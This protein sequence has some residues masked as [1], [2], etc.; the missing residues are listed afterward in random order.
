MTQIRHERIITGIIGSLSIDGQPIIDSAQIGK[1]DLP[2]DGPSLRDNSFGIVADLGIGNFTKHNTC[3]VHE[4]MR[5]QHGDRTGKVFTGLVV[6]LVLGQGSYSQESPDLTVIRS[7]DHSFVFEFRPR[8]LAAKTVGSPGPQYAMHDFVGSVSDHSREGIGHPDVRFRAIPIGFPSASGHTVQVVQADYEEVMNIVPA[9]VPT[10]RERDGGL[11]VEGYQIDQSTYGLDSLMPGNFAELSHVSPTRDMFLG[12]VRIFPLQFNPVKRVMRRYTRLVVEVIFGGRQGSTRSTRPDSLFRHVL[13]NYDAAKTWGG[14]EPPRNQASNV[15]SSVLAT[16]SWYRL[17]VAE[18][19]VYALNTQFFSS[20][21]IDVSSLDPRTI[22]IYGNGGKEVPEAVAQTRSIDLVENAIYVEGESDGRFDSGDFVV[23]FGKATRGVSYNPTT[24]MLEHYI[25]HYSEVNYYWL[26]FGGQSGKRMQTQPSS[27]SP[28]DALPDRFTDV[29]FVEEERFNLLSSGKDWY[30]ASVSPGSRYETVI[31]LPGLVQND[32]I[33]YRYLLVARSDARPSFVVSEHGSFLGSHSLGIISYSSPYAYATASPF[34]FSGQ[35]IPFTAQGTSSLGESASR[36]NFAFSTNSVTGS[37][38]I[39]WIEIKYPRRFEAMNNYLRFR[40]PDTSGV[41][42]YRLSGFSSAPFILDVTRPSDVR[43]ITSAIGTYAFRAAEQSGGVSEYC[44]AASSALRTPSAVR[45]VPNQDLQGLPFGA[46]FIIVTSQEYRTAA[47]EL[48]AY[49][50]QPQHGNLQV[51]VVDVQQI[52]NE[53][54]GGLPD[55]T[56]LR[57]FLKYAYDNWSPRPRYVLMFG[58]A[59]YDYKGIVGSI[60]NKVPTWQSL[61]SRDDVGSYSTDDF[62]A[63]LGATNAPFFVMG[64][65]SSRN[66]A[67]ARVTVEKIKRYEE[68][69]VR[70]SWKMRMLFIGD[71]SWTTEGEDGTIHSDAAEL[72]AQY[73]TP[74]EFEK[75]KIYLAE[76]PTVQ[77][78][79]GRRKP[80]AYQ[81]IIDQINQGVLA[82]NF[83]GHGN[84]TVWTHESVFSVQTSIPQ[85]VNAGQLAVFFAAT[86]NFSQFDDPQRYTG[87]EILMNKP[88]GGSIGVVSATRKVFAGSNNYMHQ[89][90]FARL[91]PR[92]LFGRLDPVTVAEAMYLFKAAGPTGNGVNDQKY[93]FMGDPTMR[94]QYPRGFVAID[95]INQQ[96]VDTLNG[97]PRLTP[98]QLK[99]LARVTVNGS[100]RG[101][102]NQII[103]GSTGT[104]LLNV[105]DVSRT[106]RINNFAPGINWS[107]VATGGLIY[108]GQNS[109]R[110]GRFTAEFVVPKDISYADTS[111]RGRITAYLASSDVDG[112]GFTSKMSVTGT[113][114]AAGS[115]IDGPR[116]DIYLDSKAFHIGD[117]VTEEPLLYL[118]LT[119]PS[120]INTSTVG[121]GHRIEAWMNNGPQSI[122]LTEFYSSNLDDYRNGAIQYKLH[123]LPLGRNSIRVR[124]WDTY[125]NASAAETY[126]VVASSDQ[127]RL[128]DV[129]NYP[130]PFSSTTDFTF[131]LNQLISIQV[132]IKI[133]TLAGRLIQTLE[134]ISPG[135]PLVRVP[136]DGRDRDGDILANGVYLYKVITRTVDGRFNSEALGRLSVLR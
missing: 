119:D 68:Q 43:L 1:G 95:S 87:S 107:Y 84:P 67:E 61:E 71:D 132:K 80:G 106:V 4:M 49:R 69:S 130:N 37:G 98:I 55:V 60:S 104:V 133:F 46:D 77:T 79:Q 94:L 89:S 23:F 20:V 120:G 13:A 136:W 129:F 72:L 85:L 127:L 26:T 64:R 83:T 29:A 14:N 63:K 50:R 70:D 88:D 125:N 117:V 17:T 101:Q 97:L 45:S 5:S 57:D 16:G 52:Y 76:Y 10:Y 92:N 66:E 65:I 108:R 8:Y 103:S 47:D 15:N 118:D 6:A 110:D 135:G 62:F 24:R 91:F 18:E 114:T 93:V 131:R 100:V 124:A 74:N 11:E 44:V 96:P 31:N 41:V 32:I 28:P 40:S 48:A 82:V 126:F 134:T 42:E 86:C 90:I 2:E 25:N 113:D 128:F 99:A 53:F 75:K 112:A 81:A 58:Q 54:G 22:K 3:K 51:S 59:S 34:D 12:T 36:L 39:D 21:G 123:S 38:W 27:P 116:I 30:G 35:G 121:L 122:D 33:R 111:G 105:N 109:V 115:D 9:P 56:A 73:Y 78:A 19:G 7:D 102:D